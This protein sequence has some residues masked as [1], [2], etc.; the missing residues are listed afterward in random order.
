MSL[1]GTARRALAR[2]LQ[3]FW[4]KGSGSPSG[5][6]RETTPFV[7][8]E[9]LEPRILLSASV[10][11]EHVFYNNSVFDGFDPGL[12]SA[13][14]AAIA[15]NLESLAPGDD[16]GPQN[17]SNYHRG[18]N[19]IMVD[20][21]DLARP[22]NLSI[23]DFAFHVG[24]VDDLTGWE[25]A[26]EPILMN[27]RQGAGVEGSDRV[28]LIWEDHAIQGQWL[29]VVV[30]GNST[31]GLTGDHGFYF[32]S[33][34]A[35][36]G[37]DVGE[38]WHVDS[39]SEALA[40]T[41]LRGPLDPAPIDFTYDYNR[42]GQVRG[43]DQ[44]I[45]RTHR[46]TDAAVNALQA[47]STP[48]FLP[49]A[50][51]FRSGLPLL[52]MEQG[53][54]RFTSFTLD[55]GNVA[56]VG[57]QV[58]HSSF[59]VFG[60]EGSDPAG[61]VVDE[62]DF[63]GEGL[64]VTEDM[65]VAI[66]AAIEGVE[67][68]EYVLRATATIE[69]STRQVSTDMRVT[70][71]DPAFYFARL[72]PPGTVQHGLEVGQTTDV[73]FTSL[74]IGRAE[75]PAQLEL[76]QVDADGDL[77]S[78]LGPLRDDGLQGVSLAGD[79]IYTGTFQ[80][81]ADEPGPLYYRVQTTIDGEDIES[82]IG[83]L[84]ATTLPLGT[85]HDD[86]NVITDADSGV[87]FVAD[88]VLI[89]HEPD[90]DPQR[91]EEIVSDFN[92]EILGSLPGLNFIQANIDGLS[93]LSQMGLV[94]GQLELYPEVVG[95]SPNT[96]FQ[97]DT[98]VPS[99]PPYAA[100]ADPYDL[101]RLDETRK[102][103][104]AGP[105]VAILDTGIQGPHPMLGN[106]V[107]GH[108][109]AFSQ[110]FAGATDW[111]G[112]GTAVAGVVHGL[113]PDTSMLSVQV[114]RPGNDGQTWVPNAVV[115]EGV[116][117]AVDLGIRVIN[118]GFSMPEAPFEWVSPLERAIERAFDEDR[119]IFAPAGNHGER[120]SRFPGSMDEVITVGAVEGLESDDAR[121]AF[122]NYGSSVNIV[123][124]GVNIPTALRGGGDTVAS[125][126]SIATPMVSGTA[127]LM[128]GQYSEWTS[129]EL[130]VHLTQSATR[131]PFVADT[132]TQLD[133][134]H[135]GRLDVFEA[136]FNG[137]F[138]AGIA[139]WDVEGSVNSI[140]RLGPFEATAAHRFAY[141]STGPAGQETAAYMY[142]PFTVSAGVHELHIAFDYNFLSE[143][144]PEFFETIF[145]DTLVISLTTEGQDPVEL[146]FE[147][148]NQPEEQW[149]LDGVE[150]L[151]IGINSPQIGQSM[152]MGW[153]SVSTVVSVV[154]G[155][156]YTLEVEIFDQ[157]DDIYNS[158]VLL[159]NIRFIVG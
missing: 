80:I 5:R 18:L 61:L 6:Y 151:T 132:D 92:G 150:D 142:K 8:L 34:V 140:V 157:G 82:D 146:A 159:D 4:H 127:S 39:S 137:S 100:G 29:E 42:N 115:A 129:S 88:Q 11:G 119:L 33:L 76:S 22:Q 79:N 30:K 134:P 38:Q 13:N 131:L 27:V 106:Q 153:Q 154:P 149:T 70:V 143:E 40:R 65:T 121:A 66:N 54:T 136:V 10:V 41:N 26:P 126:T 109:D 156:R 7:G 53:Q 23:Q 60:L 133:F 117:A 74:F 37:H 32:G 90:T 2:P 31:T 89:E 69:G 118:M 19:G 101:V 45:A 110:T 107:Y 85:Q 147:E 116:R 12:G 50:F 75:P 25:T 15:V 122:S 73:T 63:P 43:L 93:S 71:V 123:A 145:N 48:D 98:N 9:P 103:A 124:P 21:L 97:L 17:V 44:L 51:D 47:I 46:S 94:I 114:A 120:A 87:S 1:L 99:V 111:Q 36:T 59:Q 64:T 62:V 113:A 49:L 139:G 158:A 81:H 155:T 68:G 108:Y 130:R 86:L 52:T 56:E 138:E 125:G 67:A 152:P 3:R 83:V 72:S 95:A 105:A 112:H 84:H 20:V 24:N 91:L 102:V 58:V 78:I 77:I 55:V 57:D 35:W 141:A 135:A 144:W 148:I 28:T 14:D 104:T 96:L 128:W 16:A